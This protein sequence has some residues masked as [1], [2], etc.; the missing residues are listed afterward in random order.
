MNVQFKDGINSE[1]INNNT[2]DNEKAPFYTASTVV[3]VFTVQ[4]LGQF[5]TIEFFV[6]YLT[7]IF[8]QF[9]HCGLQ[10]NIFTLKNWC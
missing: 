3:F 2:D 5:V 9:S 8:L 1:L 4:K 10:F 6:V 7:Y